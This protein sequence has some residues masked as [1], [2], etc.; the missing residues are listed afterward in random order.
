[1][2]FIIV[3]AI[4]LKVSSEIL[5]LG[6]LQVNPLI[7]EGGLVHDGRIFPSYQWNWSATQLLM[8]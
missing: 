4:Y 7:S 1:M 6:S 5:K 2:E 8:L 3:D